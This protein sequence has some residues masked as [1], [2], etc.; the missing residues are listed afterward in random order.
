MD[1]KLIPVVLQDM[2][3]ISYRSLLEEFLASDHP[4]VLVERPDCDHTSLVL[5][6]RHAATAGNFDVTVAS[7][8]GKTYLIRSASALPPKRKE[9]QIS[10]KAHWQ[11][12]VG[13]NPSLPTDEGRNEYDSGRS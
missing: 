7:R 9:R 6:L 4:S 13:L 2:K 8:K 11:P 12:C 3:R 10:R 5:G 1:Y